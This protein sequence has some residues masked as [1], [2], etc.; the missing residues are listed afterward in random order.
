V[1]TSP[2]RVRF[3]HPA[4]GHGEL[5]FEAN[6][7]AVSGVSWAALATSF[8]VEGFATAV[9]MGRCSAELAAQD[10][11]LLT[12]CHSDHTAGLVAWLSAHTRRHRDRP[13]R[14]VVP[15]QRREALLA[16]LEIWP[17]LDGVRRRVNLDQVVTGAAPGEVIELDHGCAR[18]FTVR[19][20]TA[21]LGWA[22]FAG[23]DDRPFAVF[24]GD[25]TVEPFRDDPALLD[26]EIALVDC[27]FIDPGTR[28]AA[29]LGGHG[30]LQDWL[31]LLPDLSCEHLVLSHL[32]PEATAE[33]VL[34][35]L[36][37]DLPGTATLVP[38]VLGPPT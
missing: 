1:T 30:H 33:S 17:D 11:V 6:D 25:G 12:H 27:S 5:R 26:A 14:V 8:I 37:T 7:R 22:V 23:S 13:T 35:R 2:G 34:A 31:E 18:A 28:V 10:T 32:P 3:P 4:D 19:H 20:N 16:A 24:A 15:H 38:W 9:D 36:P 21:A 29:R